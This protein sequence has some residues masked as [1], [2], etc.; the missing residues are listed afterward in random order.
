MKMTIMKKCLM[1][2]ILCSLATSLHAESMFVNETN[3]IT[4]I[5]ECNRGSV[6]LQLAEGEISDKLSKERLLEAAE[7]SVEQRT[8]AMSLLKSWRDLLTLSVSIP[9]SV[10]GI[11]KIYEIEDEVNAG[12]WDTTKM[13][14]AAASIVTGIYLRNRGWFL[15]SASY[16]LEE[17]RQIQTLIE[18]APV[19]SGKTDGSPA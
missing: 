16:Y 8:K 1:L 19:S 18:N 15:T 3:V 2:N 12:H 14:Q 6:L 9:F 13:A 7:E 4:A 11:F 5:K 10:Y 17:A